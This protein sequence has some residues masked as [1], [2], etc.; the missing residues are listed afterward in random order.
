[1]LES[2][3]CSYCEE[4][5]PFAMEEN[6]EDG[7]DSKRKG[8]RLTL[9]RNARHTDSCLVLLKGDDESGNLLKQIRQAAA[10]KMRIRP[11]KVRIFD[12]SGKELLT[13]EDAST[14]V[15]NRAT[16]FVS[17]GEPCV[18]K[19]APATGTRKTADAK[20]VVIAN[21]SLVDATAIE[22]LNY[23]ANLPGVVLAVGLPD[24]HA[25]ASCPI[26]ATIATNGLIYP[27][28]VGSD[29]GCGMLLVETSLTSSSAC[30]P[31]T[32][33]RWAECI[34]LEEPWD[35][36]YSLMLERAGVE[37]T[38]FDRESLGTV[39]RGNHFAE[40]QVVERIENEEAAATFGL[41]EKKVYI[42]V[43]SGSRGYGESI[44][45]M[46]SKQHGGAGTDLETEE[47]QSYLQAHDNACKWAKINRRIIATRLVDQLNGE[48][49]RFLL[50]IT[51]NNVVKTSEDQNLTDAGV[52]E[53]VEGEIYLHRK[54]AAPT[55][56]GAVMIPGSRGALSYLVLPNAPK[57]AARSG[58][59]LAHG[60]GRR[61]ARNAARVGGKAQYPD[62]KQLLVTELQSR[63]VCDDKGLL[64]EERPEAYKDAACVVADLVGDGLCRLVAVMK[65]ILTYKMREIFDHRK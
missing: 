25:G 44:L 56:Q 39:G 19:T 27:S 64:Y 48:C 14:S 65:P 49:T 17:S 1:M 22:Q 54:G 20:L 50:D 61:L 63:V 42:C 6:K 60:A 55:D 4:L 21:E 29:I 13:E 23:V 34:Q 36:D 32:L 35:G 2:K 47:A 33:D 57:Q 46:Y 18:I 9:V 37:P 58:W 41:T 11:F 3:F 5:D 16:L 45:S 62:A 40:L 24:L 12:K 15:V 53:P 38:Q 43:H 59:S 30:K 8:L 7:D 26:G 51:H 28:L 10:N 31:R 52:S